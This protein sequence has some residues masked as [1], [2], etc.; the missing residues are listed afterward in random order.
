MHS[1]QQG[2]K[3]TK[4]LLAV[5]LMLSFLQAKESTTSYKWVYNQDKT[6]A[7]YDEVTNSE[8]NEMYWTGKCVNKKANG[9]GIA[10]FTDLFKGSDWS[11][12]RPFFH[13]EGCIKDGKYEGKA[14]VKWLEDG[15][16]AS[17]E[18]INGNFKPKSVGYIFKKRTEFIYQNVYGSNNSI[19]KRNKFTEDSPEYEKVKKLVYKHQKD[20]SKSLKMCKYERLQL[21]VADYI[22]SRG[23]VSIPRNNVL[24]K[25]K[26]L[27]WCQS[28]NEQYKETIDTYKQYTSNL[29]KK[30]KEKYDKALAEF[31]GFAY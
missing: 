29:S 31:M 26:M 16:S 28:E 1:N 22:K 12:R 30:E 13:Y 27:Q 11:E 17:V 15:D 23:I 7:I 2:Y 8:H 9:C 14:F 21:Q 25:L 3:M 10:V 20:F 5:C 24:K 6:C 4:F 19:S 18:I